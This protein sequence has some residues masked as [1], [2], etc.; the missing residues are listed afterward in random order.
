MA[1]GTFD[2]RIRELADKVG[3]GRL[4][5]HCEYNQAYA[6]I[7]HENLSYRHAPGKQAKYLEQPLYENA[8][9]YMQRLA[10]NLLD[11]DLHRAMADNMDDLAAKSADIAP[12]DLGP[13]HDSA[14]PT[15]VDDGRTVYDKAPKQPR[16]TAEELRATH[17]EPYDPPAWRA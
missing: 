16:L 7:Q 3:S 6:Q 2:D 9:R 15:V 8:D 13:L 14:H 11:G 5:G 17:R 1:A 10:D 12:L 4:S